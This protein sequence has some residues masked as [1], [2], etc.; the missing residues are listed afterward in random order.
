VSEFAK[1]TRIAFVASINAC[2]IGSFLQRSNAMRTLTSLAAG[3]LLWFTAILG[4]QRF[5]TAQEKPTSVPNMPA[6]N[7]WLADSVYPTSHFNGGATDSVLFAGPTKGKKLTRDVDVKA[8][9]TQLPRR[10]FSFRAL[11]ARRAESTSALERCVLAL[12]P[13]SGL[14]GAGAREAAV[15]GWKGHPSLFAKPKGLAPLHDTAMQFG[16]DGEFKFC[17]KSRSQSSSIPTVSS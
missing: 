4:G 15:R 10:H 7:P 13:A 3:T 9:L 16:A 17:P 2:L 1:P 12:G 14:G 8:V 6:R 5:A 11:F